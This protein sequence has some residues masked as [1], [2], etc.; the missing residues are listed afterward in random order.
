MKCVF[1]LLLIVTIGCCSSTALEQGLCKGD[2]SA[3]KYSIGQLDG[4]I[5]AKSVDEILA[6]LGP[7]SYIIGSG[8]VRYIWAFDNGE[9]LQV[10]WPYSNGRWPAA[11]VI[12][13]W[14]IDPP[15]ISLKS[16][17]NSV[18]I[19]KINHKRPNFTYVVESDSPF[20]D[21]EGCLLRIKG[22]F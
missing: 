6:I 22:H 20:V 21:V 12:P 14:H 10:N 3:I 8:I 17:D 1:S 11:N 2:N 19:V 4:V 9:R 13:A 7:P 16:N 15:V 5:D 18:A